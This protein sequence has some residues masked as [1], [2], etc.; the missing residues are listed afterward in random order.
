MSYAVLKFI[1]VSCV[2]LSYA[3]F[4]V[5]GVWMMRGSGA[6]QRR[7]VKILPHVI[8]TVLLGSAIALAVM[9]H[10]DPLNDA[11]L[12]AKVAGLLIYIGLGTVALKRGKTR[13]VRVAAWL[14]AQIVFGYIVLV[15]LS[16]N[17]ALL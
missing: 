16:K 4:T 6:L 11:W 13:K 5:R 10:Q 17:P 3:L 12:R 9:I 2:I 14:A 15:A 1:H 7:W 8:D